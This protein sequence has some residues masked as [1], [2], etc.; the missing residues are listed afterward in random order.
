MHEWDK[1]AKWIVNNKLFSAN[2]RWLIQVPRLYNV[3]K[4]TEL[5]DSFGDM[6]KSNNEKMQSCFL[7]TLVNRYI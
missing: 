2:V 5:V 3:Y 1:L 6:L 4:S 7:L